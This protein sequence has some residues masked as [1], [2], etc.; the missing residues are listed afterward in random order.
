M[1]KDWQNFLD[2]PELKFK[3]IYDIHWSS[4]RGC[5][6]PIIQNVKPGNQDFIDSYVKF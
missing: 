1:L 5:I 4:I 6:K 2:M 3:C